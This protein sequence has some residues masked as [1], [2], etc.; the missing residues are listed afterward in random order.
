M[1]AMRCEVK[2]CRIKHYWLWSHPMT[3]GSEFCLLYMCSCI[4]V[5]AWN[6]AISSEKHFRNVPKGKETVTTQV[7]WWCQLDKEALEIRK[8]EIR[9]RNSDPDCLRNMSDSQDLW[10]G[11]EWAC[12]SSGSRATLRD[13]NL[14]NSSWKRRLAHPGRLALTGSSGA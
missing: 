6:M 8:M 4:W 3:L 1:K 12:S 7:V 11:S 13:L 5:Y 14:E 10:D 2:M 9:G